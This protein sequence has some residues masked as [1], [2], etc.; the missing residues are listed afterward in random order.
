MADIKRMTMD[1]VLQ[2]RRRMAELSIATQ[3]AFGRTEP[4][5]PDKL[6]SAVFRQETGSAGVFKYSTVHECG[7]TLFYGIAM[8]HSFENGNKRT[9]LVSLLVFLDQN[10]VLLVNT[11]EDDLYELARSV[12]AHE[13]EVK[14][15]EARNSDSEV[16]AVAEWLR[17]RCRP[18]VLGDRNM[19]FKELAHLLETLGCTLEDPDAN[20]IKIRRGQ[21]MVKTGYPKKNFE[22]AV[23]EV[24]R[25]R[26]QLHLDEVH[27]VDSAGFYELEAQVDKIVN[28]YRNLMKRLADL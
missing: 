18:R 23:N 6:A 25:I 27:G 16:R 2:V 10:K 12:A 22:I 11:S 13:I 8:S 19:E 21:Y 17:A 4:L 9:A 7:A 5:A 24:K 20:F 3:D 28:N 26:R 14:A 15:G 1:E